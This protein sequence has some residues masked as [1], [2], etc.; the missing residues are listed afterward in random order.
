MI[1]DVRRDL[2]SRISRLASLL[3]ATTAATYNARWTPIPCMRHAPLLLS[4]PHD[5]TAVPE[6]IAA[7]LTDSARRVPDTDCTYPALRFRARAWRFDDRAE[8]FALRDRPEPPRN[9]VRCIPGRTRPIVSARA[10]QWQPFYLDGPVPTKLKSPS[11]R[12]VL[13]PYIAH[14]RETARSTRN[15]VAP[16][17]VGRAFDPWNVAVPVRWACP[18][19]LVAAPARFS[20]SLHHAW[21]RCWRRRQLRF[22]RQWLTRGAIS[23]ASMSIRQGFDAVS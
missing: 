12:T 11:Y 23:P 22:R 14:W 7:R 16:R 6:G 10:V 15:M 19:H 8:I 2:F 3:H 21:N 13:R 1:N 5:G 9:D 18:I 17:P 20:S 4:L